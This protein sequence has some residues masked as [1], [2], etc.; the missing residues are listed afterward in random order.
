MGDIMFDSLGAGRFNSCACFGL[1]I[2]ISVLCICCEDEVSCFQVLLGVA[3]A[4]TLAKCDRTAGAATQ[5]D[6]NLGGAAP[7]F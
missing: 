2:L 6:C 1:I 3:F 7:A 4:S 5:N